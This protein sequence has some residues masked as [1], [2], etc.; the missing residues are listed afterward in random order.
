ME[1]GGAQR[2]LVNLMEHYVDND[3]DVVLINDFKLSSNVSKYNVP[4]KVKRYFLRDGL[5]GNKI[6]KNIERVINLR[7]IVMKEN[8]DVVLSFL[9]SCNKRMLIGT[10]G[11]KTRKIVSVR[12]D[13]N[14]EYA[15][16]GLSKFFA[17]NIFKLADGVVFQTKDASSY[18]PKCVVN[19][20][21][22]IL[23]PVDLKFYNVKRDDNPKNIVT[24]GRLFPQKNQKLLIEAF[25]KICDEFKDDNLIFYGE[26]SLRQELLDLCKNLHIENRVS[27]PGNVDNVE[28]M[29]SKAKIF[30]LTSNFEGLPNALMEAMAMGLPCIS[31][32]CPCGGPRTLIDN[33]ISG[34]LV[35]VGDIDELANVLRDV[36]NDSEKQKMFATN[37]RCKADEFKPS[38]IL[39]KWDKYLFNGDI[40]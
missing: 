38:I 40:C 39:K 35:R 22:I 11:L 5:E 9:G 10:I 14:Y 33:D 37:A 31:T 34:K 16:S 24:A 29:L 27:L 28:Q 2:V 3:I 25:S 13:P 32:D 4:N 23:N 7:K 20:S 26:G 36:L 6:F 19:K 12:N 15:R 1:R 8:P 18:F 17:R 30:V 21:T